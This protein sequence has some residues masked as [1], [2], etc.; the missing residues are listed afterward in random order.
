MSDK[1]Q[2]K[3]K[4]PHVIKND[5]RITATEMWTFFWNETCGWK[6]PQNWKSKMTWPWVKL[7]HKCYNHM[8]RESHQI[9]KTREMK[10]VCTIA[11]I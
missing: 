9:E 3:R 7:I 1:E 2:E 6:E 11:R 4:K 10:I 5:K 8:H